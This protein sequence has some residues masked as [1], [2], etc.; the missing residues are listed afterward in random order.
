LDEQNEKQDR[1]K[2]QSTKRLIVGER[3][4]RGSWERGERLFVCGAEK[5]EGDGE[6][7]EDEGKVDEED[8]EEE[9]GEEAEEKAIGD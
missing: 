6:Y 8:E 9:E 3:R 2:R 7:D 4:R 1:L 5:N